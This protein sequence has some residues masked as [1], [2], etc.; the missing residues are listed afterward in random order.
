M[1]RAARQ[2]RLAG[3]FAAITTPRREGT[4]EADF[5]ASLELLDF[6]S[7][8][9]VNGVCV[10]GSTGEFVDFSFTDRQRLIYLGVKRS[11][12][13]LIAG[14]SHSSLDGAIQLADEAISS[15]A[16]A[17]LIMP[18]YF[19]RYQQPEVETFLL[20]FARETAGAVPILLY[21]IPQFTSPIEIDT[22]ARLAATGLF[23]GI[24]DSS[25]DWNYFERLLALRREE[26]QA[27]PDAALD[28]SG[29]A[30]SAASGG[31][32]LRVSSKAFAILAGHDRLAARAL[33]AGADGVISGC[34]CAIPEVL[35]ALAKAVAAGDERRVAQIER[36][37]LEFIEQIEQFP[38]PL[39]IRRAIELRGKKCGP[40]FI[41]LSPAAASRM[42]EFARWFTEWLPPA[43]KEMA[44]A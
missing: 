20:E 24:K 39:G 27:P 19:F 13:P 8:A 15:G 14:V 36:R 17:L 40:P 25:G 1:A 42:E 3:V 10:L 11:R 43:K 16:D 4:L 44:G 34:A 32:R 2:I 23:A 33:A 35:V 22:V 12:T 21:N 30:P 31:G 29:T 9:G 41:P 38:A 28:N 5:S 18:P 6:A 37:L 26:A 7:D